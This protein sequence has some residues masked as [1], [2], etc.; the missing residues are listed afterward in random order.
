MD[1]LPSWPI[2]SVLQNFEYLLVMTGIALLF[3]SKKFFFKKILMKPQFKVFNLKS[4]GASNK[5]NPLN[6]EDGLKLQESFKAQKHILIVSIS[7][8]R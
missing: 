7:D 3:S 5:R 8:M 4:H 2:L 1:T 6:F